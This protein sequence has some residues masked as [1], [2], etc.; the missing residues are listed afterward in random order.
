MFRLFYKRI[1]CSVKH[2]KELFQFVGIFQKFFRII[3][4]CSAGG[5]SKS[6]RNISV[7]IFAFDCTHETVTCFVGITCF[8]TAYSSHAV[9]QIVCSCH[10][11]GSTSC[12]FETVGG[13]I[14]DFSESTVFQGILGNLCHVTGGGIVIQSIVKAVWGYKMRIGTADSLRFFVH[15]SGEF[16]CS[17]A[18]ML[19]DCHSG[20][21]E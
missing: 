8:H 2:E 18:D 19:C 21:V 9:Q 3:P 20:I 1:I 17:S 15:Q 7:S 11:V 14:N 5:C 16:C 6:N 10:R 13:S 4:P 12:T